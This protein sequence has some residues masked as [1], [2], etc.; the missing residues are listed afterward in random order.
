MDMSIFMF[1][2]TINKEIPEFR[3]AASGMT[4]ADS[5]VVIPFAST[6]IPAHLWGSQHHQAGIYLSE[7]NGLN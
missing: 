6:V 3:F 5:A 7:I 2:N 4:L 1:I